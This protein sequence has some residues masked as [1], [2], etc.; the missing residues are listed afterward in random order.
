MKPEG[1]RKS[2]WWQ[3]PR[4]MDTKSRPTKRLRTAEEQTGS[5]INVT[6]ARRETNSDIDLRE[7]LRRKMWDKAEECV[8]SC[9]ELAGSSNDPS[10]LAL[11][12]SLWTIPVELQFYMFLPIILFITTRARSFI[13]AYFIAGLS[14]SLAFYFGANTQWSEA[15]WYKLF[16]VTLAPYFYMFFIGILCYRHFDRLKPYVE[17]KAHIWLFAFILSSLIIE[18]LGGQVGSN[19][20]NPISLI[21]LSG[22]VLSVAY[23]RPQLSEKLLKGND[24]SYGIYIYHMIVLNCFLHIG[25]LGHSGM[26]TYY[27]IV[28]A[29]AGLSWRFV[30]KPALAKKYS[31]IQWLDNLTVNSDS[32]VKQNRT[33]T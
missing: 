23:S 21:V 10:P 30:E 25:F 2:A 24:L 27:L 20:P 8:R 11:A 14:F 6:T 7:L 32:D 12:G 29:L 1:K 26:W 28:F 13:P 3:L 16:M 17:G 22:L 19:H 5:V 18:F 31:V 4:A 33:K 15:I 9:P